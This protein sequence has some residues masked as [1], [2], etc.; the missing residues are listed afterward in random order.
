MQYDNPIKKS[1]YQLFVEKDVQ[2]ILKK[3]DPFLKSMA[4]SYLS[5]RS[6]DPAVSFE[7][8]YQDNIIYA[9]KAI[10]HV[11]MEKIDEYFKFG[12]ILV[13]YLTAYNKSEYEKEKTQKNFPKQLSRLNGLVD[14]EGENQCFQIPSKSVEVEFIENELMSLFDFFYENMTTEREKIIINEIGKGTQIKDIVPILQ[15]NNS[16]SVIY[17]KN[18]LKKKFFKFMEK[19]GH[20]FNKKVSPHSHKLKH[21][22][23][24]EVEESFNRQFGGK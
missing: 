13:D 24:K 6:K 10:E 14:K 7:D 20:H 16:A 8:L 22:N 17:W 23:W 18:L 11:K 3:Y 21:I 15:A 5:N 12:S 9:L 4:A 2:S 19:Q 1:D